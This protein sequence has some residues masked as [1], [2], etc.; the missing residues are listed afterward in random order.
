M[1][2]KATN[3]HDTGQSV[4]AGLSCSDG[5]EWDG[6]GWKTVRLGKYPPN[7]NRAQWKEYQNPYHVTLTTLLVQDIAFKPRVYNE[8]SLSRFRNH[9]QQSTISSPDCT[10]VQHLSASTL[11]KQTL[12]VHRALRK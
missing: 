1:Q 8:R 3:L 5:M 4:T 6:M 11:A 10:R 7:V 2:A 9:K 12:T